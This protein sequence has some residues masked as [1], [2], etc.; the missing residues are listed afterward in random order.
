MAIFNVKHTIGTFSL[1]L[2]KFY[3]KCF[4][5]VLDGLCPQTKTFW[6]IMY[7]ALNSAPGT[8]PLHLVAGAFFA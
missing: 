7:E 5:G 3:N 1:G 6:W 4:V 2:R 8:K